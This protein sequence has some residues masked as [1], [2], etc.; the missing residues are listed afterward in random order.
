MKAP[1]PF[2]SK[3]AVPA[4]SALEFGLRIRVTMVNLPRRK[5]NF[6]GKDFTESSWEFAIF[7]SFLM[8]SISDYTWS[9]L[10]YW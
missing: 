6:L 9:T 4:S 8:W 1:S 10:I 3:L 7:C 5:A 2:V